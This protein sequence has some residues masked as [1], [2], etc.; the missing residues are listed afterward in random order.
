[1][2]KVR[3]D[4]ICGVGAGWKMNLLSGYGKLKQPSKMKKVD[5]SGRKV[6]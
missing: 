4:E 1:M 2:R 3:L 5:E 6:G